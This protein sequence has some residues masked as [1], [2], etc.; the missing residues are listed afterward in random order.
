MR[1]LILIAASFIG[2]A[3]PALAEDDVA[4]AQG[5]I[6]AQVNALEHDDAATAYGYAAPMIQ[7]MFPDP[8]SFIGMVR[9]GY[10]PVYRHKSFEFGEGRAED[11]KI[12]QQAHIVDAE[13]AVWE[14]LYTVERQPD[15]SLKITGCMLIKA[16]QAV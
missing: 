12:V 8:E 7:H 11:G 10:A 4:A 14:A 2:L 5:T 6:R 15:G 9:N 1:I 3:A 13:G 16:G